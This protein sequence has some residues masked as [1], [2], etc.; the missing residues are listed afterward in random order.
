M[1]SWDLERRRGKHSP[2]GEV[3]LS[4]FMFSYLQPQYHEYISLVAAKVPLIESGD[5][6]VVVLGSSTDKRAIMPIIRDS[7]SRNQVVLVR[8]SNAD[9][10]WLQDPLSQAIL[11]EFGVSSGRPCQYHG[12]CSRV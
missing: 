6:D 8:G 4:A 5:A 1:W 2:E 9:E 10:T 7:L 12:K 11:D 3:T